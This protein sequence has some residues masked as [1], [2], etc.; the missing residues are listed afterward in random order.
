[1]KPIRLSQ[2]LKKTSQYHPLHLHTS[3][4]G[5]NTPVREDFALLI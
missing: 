3:Q 5:N 1:M 4:I 2:T